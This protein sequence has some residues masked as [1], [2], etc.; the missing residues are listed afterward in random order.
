MHPAIVSN[1]P[2]PE[3]FEEIQFFNGKNY[4]KGIACEIMYYEPS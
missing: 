3:T 2:S 4:Y 1:Y